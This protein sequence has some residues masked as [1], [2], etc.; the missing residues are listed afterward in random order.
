MTEPNRPRFGDCLEVMREDI[1]SESVDLIYLDTPV[2]QIYMVE[3][4][5]EGRKPKLP[6]AA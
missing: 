5:F 2:V 1:A 4:Y 3:D 6:V